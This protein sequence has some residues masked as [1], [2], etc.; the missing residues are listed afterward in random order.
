MKLLDVV[1]LVMTYHNIYEY[2]KY[3]TDLLQQLQK[4]IFDE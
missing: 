2:Y 4:I 1:L 3:C